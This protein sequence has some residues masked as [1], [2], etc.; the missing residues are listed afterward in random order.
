M[1]DAIKAVFAQTA[2]QIAAGVV[3]GMYSL[4]LIAQNA[5]SSHPLHLDRILDRIADEA[6]RV[7]FSFRAILRFVLSLLAVFAFLKGRTPLGWADITVTLGVLSL[8]N[9]TVLDFLVEVLRRT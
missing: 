1:L 2:V 6:A 5:R 3:I 8:A 4:W 7:T 9:P